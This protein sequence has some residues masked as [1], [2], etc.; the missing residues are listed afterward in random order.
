MI[1]GIIITLNESTHIS[2]CITSLREVCDD[3]IVVDS[4]STD[5]TAEKAGQAGA[6]VISQA[7]L[8]DGPQK[9]VGIEFARN[10]WIL[11]VDA[12]ERLTE[13]MV[14]AIR[15]LDLRSTPHDA[16]AFRRRNYVGSRWIRYCGW[17]P[18]Y[19]IRLFDR[20]RTRFA[21]ARQH[22]SVQATNPQRVQA[23]LIHYSY[24]D[25]GQLF[26]KPG[27]NFSGRAAKIM[28]LEGKR[29]SPVSPFLHGA[30]AMFRKYLLQGGFL[31]GVDGMT[32][33]LSAAVNSYIKYA[34]L[35]E[36]QRDPAVLER[37]DFDRVW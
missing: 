37:T 19:C 8:G 9:N 24:Q 15:K 36:L 3:I 12:D 25:L 5:D 30:S 17:Y 31:G 13:G 33:A 28:Y 14:E 10:E 11:S 16:F 34:K 6:R 32:V 23:D 26:C 1:T 4:L 21:E 2:D 20:R 22:S 7:Y 29:A 18:D 27:R 35:L